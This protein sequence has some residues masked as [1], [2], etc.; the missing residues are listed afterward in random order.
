MGGRLDVEGDDDALDSATE[1]AADWAGGDG[2]GSGRRGGEL[3]PAEN[4]LVGDVYVCACAID[5]QASRSRP[6]RLGGGGGGG[7][8]AADANGATPEKPG[9]AKG[10]VAA[11]LPAFVRT[12]AERCGA[13]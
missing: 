5:F 13:K 3:P 1:A 8:G 6:V 12:E 4:R 2:R 7:G 9:V 11:V 10:V